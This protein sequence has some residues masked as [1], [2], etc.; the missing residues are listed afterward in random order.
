[1]HFNPSPRLVIPVAIV[2]ATASIL[3]AMGRPPICTCGYVALWHGAVDSGN[4]QHILDWYSPSHVIHGFLFYAGGWLLFRR[5]PAGA[6]FN[7][8]LALE[9]SWEIVENTPF[10]IDRY[11]TATIALGYTGDSVINSLSDIGCMALGFLIAR[12]LPWPVTLAIGVSLELLT[13]Y[14]IRDNLTLNVLM[15]IAPVDVIRQWQAS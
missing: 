12:R 15:L 5:W 6:R 4:S 3:L 8:A 1:V 7:L 14:V 10:I 2:L 9:T 13:L 11:R